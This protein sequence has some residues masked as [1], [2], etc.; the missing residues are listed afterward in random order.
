MSIPEG[1]AKGGHERRSFHRACE[2]LVLGL[3]F[4]VS[5][6]LIVVGLM[7]EVP[8]YPTAARGWSDVW[9]GLLWVGISGSAMYSV[10]MRERDT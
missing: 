7:G 2:W 4:V 6:Q 8:V 3:V 9:T 1:K 10:L 5:V